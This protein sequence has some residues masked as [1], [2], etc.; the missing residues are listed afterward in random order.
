MYTIKASRSKLICMLTVVL[1]IVSF[2]LFGMKVGLEANFHHV[3]YACA[4]M[5]DYMAVNFEVTCS[6]KCCLYF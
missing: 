6:N 2:P 1:G 4:N 3:N 5:A